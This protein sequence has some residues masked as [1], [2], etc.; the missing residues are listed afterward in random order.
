MFTEIA[1]DPVNIQILILKVWNKEKV[2][3]L[4]TSR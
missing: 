4:Q 1:H 2:L 3:P